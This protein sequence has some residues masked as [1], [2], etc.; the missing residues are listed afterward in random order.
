MT[1]LNRSSAHARGKAVIETFDYD[2][3][4]L[5]P[6]RMDAQVRQARQ[7]YSSIPNDSILKGF[8]RQSGLPH[9][10]EDLRGWCR[11][12]TAGIFGQLLS[13]MARM[14]RATGDRSLW[15]KAEALLAG[16]YETLPADG[17]LRMRPYDW[18]KLV[19]GLVDLHHYAGTTSA[20]P[21]LAQTTS[22]AARTFDRTRRHSDNFDFWGAE[23]GS[24]QEWYTLPEN[25]YR[26]YLATGERA[27]KD[28]G[29]V[30]LYD[31]YWAPLEHAERL[32]RSRSPC[33]RTAMP[34]PSAA[35]RW[36]MP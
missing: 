20:L 21:I 12:K 34:I 18:E 11:N 10:G 4:R 36:H 22:W 33:M 30:W 35:P 29:D 27:Y 32:A 5:L 9:P 2:G 7:V 19:C 8:R 24:T 15:D 17:N 6:G 14:G 25:L 31:D 3:V 16:W 28:F 1:D 23:P 13:G 26:A